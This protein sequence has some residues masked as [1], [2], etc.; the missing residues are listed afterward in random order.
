MMVLSLV[1]QISLSRSH[2]K[3]PSLSAQRRNSE[4]EFP[5]ASQQAP[6]KMRDLKSLRSSS[7]D[8]RNFQMTSLSRGGKRGKKLS[9]PPTLE[10]ENS[11]RKSSLPARGKDTQ[12]QFFTRDES[13]LAYCNCITSER[14]Q[15]LAP[16][17]SSSSSPPSLLESSRTRVVIFPIHDFSLMPSSS[18]Q[19]PTPNLPN[20]PQ[21][22]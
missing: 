19:F 1:T 6:G 7:L 13:K 21:I 11:R 9:H 16:P 18:A 20:H 17:S 12:S 22:T 5:C 2:P 8:R 14:I 10:K 3:V 4:S 15:F